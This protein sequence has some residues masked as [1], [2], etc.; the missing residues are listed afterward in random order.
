MSEFQITTD[1]LDGTPIGPQPRRLGRTRI[2]H[3]PRDEIIHRVNLFH[4][5]KL[6]EFFCEVTDACH[7]AVAP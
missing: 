4:R 7:T 3:V 6:A 5:I 2:K 1:P